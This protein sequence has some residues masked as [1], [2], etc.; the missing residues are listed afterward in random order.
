MES[1]NNNKEVLEAIQELATHMDQRFDAVDQRFEQVDKRFEQVDKRFE[2]IDE[3]FDAVDQRFDRVDLRFEQLEKS[4]ETRFLELRKDIAIQVEGVYKRIDNV[5]TS[6]GKRIDNVEIGLGN[7][8][9]NV[10]T[11]LGNRIDLVNE[12]IDKLYTAVDGFV[13]LHRKLEQEFTMLRSKYQ[14][15]EERLVLVEQKVGLAA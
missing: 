12:R 8:I 10:E 6:L 3:R 14:R 15:L 11:S 5:E 13:V 1:Q 7:R 2:Q 9:D 4:W